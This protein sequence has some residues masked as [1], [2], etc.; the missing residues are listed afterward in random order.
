MVG[1][2]VHSKTVLGSNLLNDWSISVWILCAVP[3]PICVSACSCFLPQPK[4]M[5]VRSLGHS[6]L[7]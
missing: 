7:C 3:V 2:V 4:D 6:S 5:Q 1:S